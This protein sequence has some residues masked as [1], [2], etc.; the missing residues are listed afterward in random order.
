VHH[1]GPYPATTDARTTSI[2]TA[3]I[4]RWVRPVCYQD[5][6]QSALPAELRNENPRN[7]WRLVDGQR[8][9]EK[10]AG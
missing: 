2:G 5:F 10:V 1:S 7:I 6:P 3:A 9:K 8:T 4:E